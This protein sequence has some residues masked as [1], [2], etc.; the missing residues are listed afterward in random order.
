MF[1]YYTCT[2]QI[3]SSKA[4]IRRLVRGFAVRMQQNLVFSRQGVCMK[5]TCPL[6]IQCL[7]RRPASTWRRNN[8][9]STSMRRHD[10]ALTLIWRCF[11]VVCQQ[12]VCHEEV[13]AS[14]SQRCHCGYLRLLAIYTYKCMVAKT[15]NWVYAKQRSGLAWA[16]T[17]WSLSFAHEDSMIPELVEDSNLIGLIAM[18]IWIFSV[19]KQ[20]FVTHMHIFCLTPLRFPCNWY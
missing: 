3:A 20:K 14:T 1:S 12:G 2:M 10:V 18:V 19:R 15:L 17:E 9:V 16:S 7:R 11:K 13:V 8:V 6:K 4:L 5:G